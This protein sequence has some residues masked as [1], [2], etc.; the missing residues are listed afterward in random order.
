[1]TETSLLSFFRFSFSLY[2]YP[3]DLGEEMDLTLHTHGW[4]WI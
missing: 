2:R 3:L 4:D 1:M